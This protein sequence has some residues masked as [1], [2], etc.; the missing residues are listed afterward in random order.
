MEEGAIL[1]TPAGRGFGIRDGN[2]IMFVSHTG[3]VHPSGF[4][5]VPV[6]NVR[7]RSIVSLYRDTPVFQDLRDVSRFEGKCGWCEY[8]EI[9]GGS[10]ARAFAATGNY[11]AADPLCAY[12]PR[13]PK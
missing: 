4:L 9:C 7:H 8:A 2:G 5:P 10:R 12:R 3:D 6:G 11:L 13:P 1:A